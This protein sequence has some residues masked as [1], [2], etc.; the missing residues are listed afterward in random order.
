MEKVNVSV[1]HRELDRLVVELF[2]AVLKFN[3][4]G[5][6]VLAEQLRMI[7]LKSGGA[8]L[9]FQ[10]GHEVAELR[11][12]FKYLSEGKWVIYIARRCGYCESSVY[13]ALARRFERLE[14]QLR[15][16]GSASEVR[17]IS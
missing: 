6:K 17:C 1:V 4:A 12:V 2:K 14:A 15:Q 5:G 3:G 16:L 10:V 13:K 11:I 8:W 9:R 7:G